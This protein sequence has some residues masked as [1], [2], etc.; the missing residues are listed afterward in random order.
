MGRRR[1]QQGSPGFLRKYT[2]EGKVQWEKEFRGWRLRVVNE[3]GE[4]IKP[5]E[6][7]E[8][9][10]S[11]DNIMMGYFEDEEGTKNA[12][13]NG[14]LFTGDLGTVD[15]DGYIYLTARSKEII[16]V[17]GKRIS[18]KEIEAVILAL[19]EVIDCTI[20]GVEDEIEGEML[21][22]T[23]TVRKDSISLVNKDKL[24]KHCSQHLALFKVP[25]VYEFKDDLTIS[26]TG[27]KI[28]KS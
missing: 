22:A 10:A 20:E 19:P 15:E 1:P 25:Q 3:K 24:I 4:K 6:T 16:K 26:P 11:G 9:I 5:G 28:K 12:I 23:V 27:K 21:K 2:K 8:V 7:G 18:P 13:R 17:R 14:W